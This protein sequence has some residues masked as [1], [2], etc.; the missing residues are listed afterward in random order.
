MSLE[1]VA[2]VAVDPLH[3]LPARTAEAL[4]DICAAVFQPMGSQTAHAAI[5]LRGSTVEPDRLPGTPIVVDLREAAPAASSEAGDVTFSSEQSVPQPF[6]NCVLRDRDAGAAPVTPARGDRTLATG[7]AGPLWTRREDG[8]LRIHRLAVPLPELEGQ[9]LVDALRAERFMQ[10]LPAL[11]ALREAAGL[12]AAPSPLPATIVIDDPNLHTSRYG[13]L[14]F[15]DIRQHALETPLHVACAMIPLDAWYASSS[16]VAAFADHGPL[17]LLV[18]GNNHVSRELGRDVSDESAHAQLSQAIR[19]IERFEQRTQLPVSRVMAAPHGSCA[20]ATPRRLVQLGFDALTISRPRPWG[21]TDAE[22]EDVLL[23]ARPTEMV[24]GAPLLGRRH[25]SRLDDV[26]FSAL[27][28][29]PLVVY[30]HHWDWPESGASLARTAEAVSRMAAVRWGRIDAGLSS[31]VTGRVDGSLARVRLGARRVSFIVPDGVT[32]IIVDDAGLHE[33]DLVAIDD[34]P[35]H[36]GEAVTV[37]SGKAVEIAL[38]ASD[39]VDPW[40]VPTPRTPPYAVARRVATELRDR[41]RGLRRRRR[42]P[43]PT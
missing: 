2:R 32:A 6:R 33:A 42:T 18:H 8:G 4:A 14:D 22:R 39:A 25:I 31:L 21:N 17:S 29:Q 9:Q 3:L 24:D 36:A 40:T 16:A 5:L 23:G 19:R 30:G 34:R 13:Y 28:G 20:R 27:L 1:P 7:V 12:S 41:V 37:E 38:I 43:A 11:A 35:A 10:L 26:R 15:D